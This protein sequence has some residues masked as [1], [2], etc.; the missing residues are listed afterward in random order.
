M[1]VRSS[2]AQIADRLDSLVIS[3]VDRSIV[4]L[5]GDSAELASAVLTFL[6]EPRTRAQV[7]A[8]LEELTGEPLQ[9]AEVVEELLRVLLKTG[10]VEDVGAGAQSTAG[11]RTPKPS[12]KPTRL[13]LGISGAIAAA[14]APQLVGALLEQHFELEIA[15][16]R[17]A[18]RMVSRDVLEALLHRRVH[19]SLR[20]EDPTAPAPH[21]R[22]AEWAEV[23]LVCPATA[24][25]ISRIAQGSCSD[26][27]AAVAIS[28]R[29]PVLIAPSMNPAM[30]EAPAVRRNLEL[31]R[32]D[33]MWIVRAGDGVEVAHEPAERRRSWGAAP[34]PEAVLRML[35]AVLS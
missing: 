1:L 13:V 11:E 31:L 18:L 30:H 20:S 25:T 24:T 35:R 28:T 26:V 16:T 5:S 34:Q 2:R 21:I 15:M 29:A 27:V 17:A 14:H 22:L 3:G 12:P 10:A 32:N 6:A 4:R 7:L 33:G 23:V 19:S 9:H 8:H